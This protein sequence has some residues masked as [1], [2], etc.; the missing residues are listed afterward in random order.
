M[1]QDV[2]HAKMRVTTRFSILTIP[3]YGMRALSHEGIFGCLLPSLSPDP[4][5]RM[6]PL[7]YQ[8]FQHLTICQ[9]LLF[10]QA[11][12][13]TIVHSQFCELHIPA[14]VRSNPHWGNQ[15]DTYTNS[16]VTSRPIT[17]SKSKP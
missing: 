9:S 3:F 17:D 6:A 1:N 4:C 13:L 11:I 10:A 15:G 5:F 14:T 7:V 8:M 16:R 2:S 12:H